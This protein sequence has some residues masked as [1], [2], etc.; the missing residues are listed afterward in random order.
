MELGNKNSYLVTRLTNFIFIQNMID[1]I[2]C[3]EITMLVIML[4]RFALKNYCLKL[5]YFI[6]KFSA[7]AS[8]L[9]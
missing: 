3:C 5:I 9:P 7:L 6:M 2:T 8:I 4:F 1:H